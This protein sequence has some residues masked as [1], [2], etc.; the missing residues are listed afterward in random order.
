[1]R[2]TYASFLSQPRTASEILA[3]YSGSISKK[4]PQSNPLAARHVVKDAV[5]TTKAK[6]AVTTTKAKTAAEAEKKAQNTDVL[7]AEASG[8]KKPK[9]KLGKS[10]L[11]ESWVPMDTEESPLSLSIKDPS[12][13]DSSK[14]PDAAAPQS[15]NKSSSA[16]SQIHPP[17]NPNTKNLITSSK[18]A[19]PCPI[20]LSR[21]FHLQLKC[22]L[23][24]SGEDAILDRIVQLEAEGG[25]E[26]VI[27][28]LREWVPKVRQKSTSK[29]F[30]KQETEPSHGKID[31]S[32]HRG[33]PLP[34]W[35]PVVSLQSHPSEVI[36]ESTNEGSE[37]AS[38]G[39]SEEE[40]VQSESGSSSD[41]PS[42]SARSRSISFSTNLE[43]VDLDAL[44]RGP[45][46]KNATLDLSR[47]DD[48]IEGLE[49]KSHSE[50]DG[51]EGDTGWL[52]EE[53]EEQEHRLP[54]YPKHSAFLRS[55]SSEEVASDEEDDSESSVGEKAAIVEGNSQLSTDEEEIEP[56]G[57]QDT[58]GG[59]EVLQDPSTITDN[60]I[61][62]QVLTHADPV[63]QEGRHATP[64]PVAVPESSP[65]PPAATP[66]VNAGNSSEATSFELIKEVPPV[67]PAKIPPDQDP[68]SEGLSHA[69]TQLTT[70]RPS[71]TT[72]IRSNMTPFKAVVVP[73]TPGTARR[74]KDRTG[75]LPLN[76]PDDEI[77]IN[78][79][80]F[81]SPEKIIQVKTKEKDNS[82]EKFQRRSTRRSTQSMSTPKPSLPQSDTGL[83]S[84]K[85]VSV[86]D[87][88][89]GPSLPSTQPMPTAKRSVPRSDTGL[90]SARSMSADDVSPASQLAVKRRG[91]PR[92]TEAVKAE[93]QALREAQRAAR[94]AEK[95][96]KN[97]L[98]RTGRNDSSRPKNR[99]DDSV[100]KEVPSEE[101]SVS[102]LPAVT[103]ATPTP[104]SQWTSLPPALT[105]PST[106]SLSSPA[107]DELVSSTESKRKG[108]SVVPSNYAG[109]PPRSSP[110]P[111]RLNGVRSPGSI[112]LTSGSRRH[113]EEDVEQM[114]VSSEVGAAKVSGA[115]T[116]AP[117]F[118]PGASEMSQSQIVPGFVALSMPEA[119]D[120]DERRTSL[121]GSSSASEGP[122]TK[123]STVPHAQAVSKAAFPSLSQLSFDKFKPSFLLTS[124]FSQ[125]QGTRR[126]VR[127]AEVPP[128]SGEEDE[129][130]DDEDDDESSGTEQESSHVPKDKRAGVNMPARRKTRSRGLL[131]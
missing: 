7:V 63:I 41:D 92:L 77:G 64:A 44:I 38:S 82:M 51:V 60:H 130:E 124:V 71:A 86:D 76:P 111:A 59:N 67:T 83:S 74:M 66:A 9:P 93:R 91:R 108:G 113:D 24:N 123:A 5:T 129:E 21:P 36:V 75:K 109:A 114:V 99:E 31:K 104:M 16:V 25:H 105:S 32:E 45:S 48:D 73:Q 46:L 37:S 13:T 100:E 43:Q 85:S 98:K 65:T 30:A 17:R 79:P 29:K 69:D 49:S 103:A 6:D 131:Q 128:E 96:E 120:E 122:S 116:Q 107:V 47:L 40:D 81:Q 102:P 33:S 3:N 72:P 94:A 119:T 34:S 53:E 35:A 15:L 70:S 14:V 26:D 106:V 90:S 118:L 55:R 28:E 110:V 78:Q 121:S 54:K 125:G 2:H 39:S 126:G 42:S 95:R 115:A 88:Q 84:T 62:E 19:S 27:S 89:R 20:C 97:E 8:T 58:T 10:R 11:S 56:S 12:E 57:A 117:L 101:V 127:S 22:P 1:M 87:A 61:C 52:E 50:D 18:L 68:T 23:I 80:A 4:K 112:S